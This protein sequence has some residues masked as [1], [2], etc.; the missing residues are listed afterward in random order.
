MAPKGTSSSPLRASDGPAHGPSL[1]VALV[2][3][4]AGMASCSSAAGESPGAT[5]GATCTDCLVAPTRSF[6]ASGSE[7][8]SCRN[9]G[10][11]LTFG[12]L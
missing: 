3:A 2:V 10:Q 8:R 5:S 9:S 12:L 6:C 11:A 1:P 4:I 7:G